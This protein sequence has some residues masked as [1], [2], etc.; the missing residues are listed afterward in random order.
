MTGLE[1]LRLAGEVVGVG[2]DDPR[3][4]AVAA[5]TSQSRDHP[6]RGPAKGS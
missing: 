3:L 6:D 5:R 2:H 4:D 1:D